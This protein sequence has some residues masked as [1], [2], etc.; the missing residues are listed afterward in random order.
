MVRRQRE[1]LSNTPHRQSDGRVPRIVVSVAPVAH[2]GSYLPDGCRN[3][4]T[5][6]EIAEECRRCEAAGA[7]MVHLHVRNTS[8]KIV[9]ETDTFTR[10]LDLV[11]GK[12]RLIINGSTGGASTLSREERCVSLTDARVEVASLNMGSTNF[13]DTVYINTLDDIR[14]WAGRIRDAG[15]VPELEVFASGMVQ[16]ALDLRAEGLLED[17]LHFNI[18]LGFPGSTP[19]TPAE[20]MHMASGVPTESSWAFLHEGMTSLRLVAAA[21]GVGASGLRV[22]YE[23]GG[24]LRPDQPARSNAE[25]VEALVQMIRIAGCEP[26]SIAEARQILAIHRRKRG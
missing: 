25:L 23:D 26:A 14:F 20:L 13:G 24:H 5:P 4:I 6:E 19:A 2:S 7:A 21:L 8:G 16:S 17:P 22:G 3:P 9:A 18:C 10:T 11:C 12:T 1:P 15:V